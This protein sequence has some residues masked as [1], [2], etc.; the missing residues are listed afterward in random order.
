MVLENIAFFPLG[1]LPLIAWLGII[2]YAGF[3][4]TAL[5]PLLRKR[6]KMIPFTWHMRIAYF[7][8]LL[9]TLHGI[10]GIARFF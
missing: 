8:L 4:A 7:S 5:V 9:A 3:I 6:G 2:T 1:P 10:L